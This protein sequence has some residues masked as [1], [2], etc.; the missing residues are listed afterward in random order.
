MLRRYR[1]NNLHNIVF[2]VEVDCVSSHSATADDDARRLPTHIAPQRGGRRSTTASLR[3]AI[4]CQLQI[5]RFPRSGVP[6]GGRLFHRYS[7]LAATIQDTSLYFGYRYSR[8][9]VLWLAVNNPIRRRYYSPFSNT[10]KFR[11][12]LV[13]ITITK[14]RF[15][16]CTFYAA[17]TRW[18][19]NGIVAIVIQLSCTSRKQLSSFIIIVCL[20]RISSYKCRL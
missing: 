17:V 12:V 9:S 15:V 6:D 7:L 16:K 10:S 14:W 2:V 13:I 4:N 5:I 11:Y 18:K 1:E 8:H 20:Y 19:R 3:S